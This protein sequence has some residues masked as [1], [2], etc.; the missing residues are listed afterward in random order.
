MP[1]YGAIITSFFTLSIRVGNIEVDPCLNVKNSMKKPEVTIQYFVD[2][3]RR[4]TITF[5]LQR[6]NALL[7]GTLFF[8]VWSLAATGFLFF[9]L[10]T[11]RSLV[12]RTETDQ[13]AAVVAVGPDQPSRSKSV[14]SVVTKEATVAPATTSLSAKAIDT[15][16]LKTEAPALVPS[17]PLPL[18]T[19]AS[20]MNFESSLRKAEV[21]DPLRFRNVR[22]T[23]NGDHLRVSADIE[24]VN[25][26][27]VEGYSFMAAEY[28]D[29]EGRSS[30][31]TS[32]GKKD[33]EAAVAADAF[34]GATPFRA[35]I[36]SRK[37]FDI[38]HSSNRDGKL[39]AVKLVAKDK[40]T[41]K[42]IVEAVS[43]PD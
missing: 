10:F 42:T 13:R 39:V 6:L 22:I 5:S 29:K 40:K 35:K 21:P 30:M 3:G 8:C 34:A 38:V 26:E 14:A 11:G 7:A 17:S 16:P 25:G 37:R 19:L 27:L 41:G 18:Y 4:R 43:L 9:H 31:Q 33:W 36:L 2:R 23:L 24:R 15:E 32:H 1:I 28:L 12:P 20:L